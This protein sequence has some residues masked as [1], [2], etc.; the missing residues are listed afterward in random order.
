MPT[1]RKIGITKMRGDPRV[2][3]RVLTTALKGIPK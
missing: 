2:Y 3:A 1:T